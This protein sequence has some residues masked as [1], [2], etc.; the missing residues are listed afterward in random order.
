MNACRKD[1]N[2]LA[3]AWIMLL[4]GGGCV[5]PAEGASLHRGVPLVSIYSSR[6][7]GAHPQN[8][9]VLQDRREILYVGNNEGI[10]SFD[11][12]QWRL[13]ELPNL[14][15]VNALG[16]DGEGT[17]YL[18][19]VGEFG[20][21]YSNPRGG[22]AYYS[23]KDK[24]PAGEE[25]FTNI[26]HCMPG[27]DRFYFFSDEKILCWDGNQIRVIPVRLDSY[28]VSAVEENIY[29]RIPGEP[30]LQTLRGEE[31][32]T[33][34]RTPAMG[35][36]SMVLPYGE[37][38]LLVGTEKGELWIYSLPDPESSAPPPP[39]EPLPNSWSGQL[40]GKRMVMAFEHVG[41]GLYA[42]SVWRKGLFLFRRDGELIWRLNES[43][44]LETSEILDIHAGTR[45]DIWLASN[46]GVVR[47]DASVPVYRFGERNS[48]EYFLSVIRHKGT[49]Y[50]GGFGGVSYLHHRANGTNEVRRVKGAGEQCFHLLSAGNRLYAAGE[51][52]WRI[53]KEEGE[54]LYTTEATMVS[55]GWTPRFPGLVFCGLY[56]GFSAFPVD[57]PAA[58][59]EVISFEE[60]REPIRR[61]VADPLGNL[62]LT[63]EYGG[64]IHLFFTGDS[65]RDYI[66]QR[67]TVTDG[68][69][70]DSTNFPDV[71]DGK[72][73]I[74]TVQGVYEMDIP[75]KAKLRAE[76][77]PAR[78]INRL[79][80]SREMKNAMVFS[81]PVARC[82][83]INSSGGI[84]SV[85][86]GMDPER[87]RSVETPLQKIGGVLGDL[88]PDG[89][90]N[91][92][93]VGSEGLFQYDRSRESGI[94]RSFPILIRRVVVNGEEDI[95]RGNYGRR[96]GS[97][98]FPS[99]MESIAPAGDAPPV[100]LKPFRN[101]L[102]FEYAGIYYEDVSNLRYSYMLK[103]YDDGWSEWKEDNRKEYT[104]LPGGSYVFRV[105]CRNAYGRV[106]PS[107]VF[108]FRIRS[109]WYRTPWG[110]IL[111]VLLA[112][113]TAWLFLQLYTARLKRNKIRLEQMVKKRTSE[114]TAKNRE[115]GEKNR[116]ITAKAG[117]LK[118]AYRKV[119]MLSLTDTLTGLYNR[120]YFHNIIEREVEISLRQADIRQQRSLHYV[121]GILM[122]DVDHFKKINDI[123]GHRCGDT[124]LRLVSRRLKESLRS[125]DL[126]VRWGG[127][128]FLVLARS[129][130]FDD[131]RH[132]AVRLLR[133]MSAAPF[134][135]EGGDH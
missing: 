108:P 106:S 71:F 102:K 87:F 121:M 3:V 100:T 92:W 125:S 31:P 39:A 76:V 25:G 107:A 130:G 134:D 37:D 4:L 85:T 131:T 70:S 117:E 27:E 18:G 69:P 43:N 56:P 120:R 122:I 105:R 90:G 118:K 6:D 99:V 110:T 19:G 64:I 2:R 101:S 26:R 1:G 13:L 42:V 126:I 132:L 50:A 111:F 32:V 112:A 53:D 65:P 40:A 7:F 94:H 63:S 22:L 62:W 104:G 79:L 14:S 93:V 109:P 8:M 74:G 29:F 127:E 57:S 12:T 98:G 89:K 28:M 51:G 82:M 52:L 80:S 114:I 54:K 78:G 45:G 49:V 72:L 123:Y 84:T 88:Y 67:Y 83:W 36:V 30:G 81:D 73:Y 23:L 113:G 34:P 124:F 38:R 115:I 35:M 47:I 55:L 91:L 135:L 33:L 11:G 95:Y 17:V 9:A 103:G 66:L 20:F 59:G 46:N 119:E 128:E 48:S 96:A 68:L 16:M 133:S 60:I 21:L 97:T 24:V 116:L 61:I 77:K 75:G 44:G 10:L 15:R 129:K 41:P 58:G 5:C 86:P